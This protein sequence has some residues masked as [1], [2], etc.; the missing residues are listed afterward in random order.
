MEQ[1][2]DTPNGKKKWSFVKKAI[3]SHYELV[4]ALE[5]IVSYIDGQNELF[6]EDYSSGSIELFE[7]KEALKKAKGE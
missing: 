7:A 5:N 1:F 6:H 3:E 4:E 2:I